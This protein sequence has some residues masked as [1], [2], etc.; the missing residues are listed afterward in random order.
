MRFLESIS[1]AFKKY[2]YRERLPLAIMMIFILT[3]NRYSHW[4]SSFRW[5]PDGHGLIA[6]I[7]YAALYSVL[8]FDRKGRPFWFLWGIV[9]GAGLAVVLL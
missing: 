5:P 8:F 2:P 7:F 3:W 4:R 6:I 9:V 1:S